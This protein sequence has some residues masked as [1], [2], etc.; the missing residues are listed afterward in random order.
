V[1]IVSEETGIISMAKG[2]K[3][4]RYL[5][6]ATLREILEGMYAQPTSGLKEALRRVRKEKEAAK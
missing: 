6:A 4:T 3:L 2:G 1:L 5:D